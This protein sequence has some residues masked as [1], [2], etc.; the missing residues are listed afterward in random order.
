MIRRHAPLFL[1]SAVAL[2]LELVVIRWLSSEVRI[3]AYFKNM[4]LMGAFLGFG[5]GFMMHRRAPTLFQWFPRLFFVLSLIIAGAHAFGITHVIFV[6]PREFLLYGSGFGDHAADAVPSMLSTIKALL[7]ILSLFALVVATFASLTCLLGSLL[8]RDEPLVAYSVNVGGSLVGILAFSLASVVWSPPWVWLLV[9]LAPL[10]YFYG[11]RR[12]RAGVYFAAAVAVAIG[13]DLR[14]PVT[15]SPYYRIEVYRQDGDPSDSLHV[16]VNYDGFQ[17][18]NDLSTGGLGRLSPELRASLS[19]HYDIPYRLAKRP[20]ERVLIL[21]GGTGNDAAAAVRNGA[22]VVDVVEIDPAI[23]RIGRERHPEK[24]YENPAVSVH[25]DDARSFLQKTRRGYDLVIFATLDSHAAFSSMSS[26]RMDNFVF[27]AESVARVKEL[28]RPGGGVAINLFAIKPW[29]VQRHHN[30][31][32]ASFGSGILCFGSPLSQEMILLAGELFGGGGSLGVTDYVKMEP[33]LDAGRVEP[34]DDDWPF[35]F[36]KERGIPIHYLLPLC[37]IALGSLAPMRWVCGRG[38]DINWHLFFMGAAFLLIETKAVTTLALVLGSTWLTNSIVLGS[39][40]LVILAANFLTLRFRVV[41]FA[42]LYALLIAGLILN[43]AFPF[44]W[45]NRF[46]MGV[47]MVAGGGI[48]SVPIF[49]AA[50]IFA[51]AFAAV[52]SPS[53]A[54]ASNLFGSVLG[55]VLEYM[56]MLVGLR[57]LN[58]IAIGLYAASALALYVRA[59]GN[60]ALR[61]AGCGGVG[62]AAPS[63]GHRPT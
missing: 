26:L 63:P 57:G 43:F 55:G 7:V 1:L 17:V 22:S 30:T 59:G 41:G 33:G 23:V 52:P 34:T 54:L 60:G 48:I 47:R 36:L 62:S 42:A 46:D 53:M 20:V 58:L 56:D 31:L 35:L 50:L 8:D 13:G 38:G 51:R 21:G 2:F 25:V 10:L 29:L 32:A 39:I 40:L 37:L 45:L 19:R 18:I 28:L 49:F 27:T 24:P 61:A 3:F 14:R 15:W 44:D 6:D 11:G 16:M 12:W 5:V 4:A 9:G